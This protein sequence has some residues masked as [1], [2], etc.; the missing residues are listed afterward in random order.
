[1]H[2]KQNPGLADDSSHAGT[3][4]TFVERMPTCSRSTSRRRS[5]SDVASPRRL[6]RTTG[7][8]SARHLATAPECRA[9]ARNAR[10][11]RR[12]RARPPVLRLDRDPEAVRAAA[13]S[14]PSAPPFASQP[15]ASRMR[16]KSTPSGPPTRSGRARIAAA[17]RRRRRATRAASTRAP[18]AR[19]CSAN[20]TTPQPSIAGLERVGEPP[21]L[22]RARRGT[23]AGPDARAGGSPRS[24]SPARDRARASRRACPS[25]CGG[26]SRRPALLEAELEVVLRRAR[27]ARAA[28]RAAATCSGVSW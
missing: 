21:R 23:P 9:G 18:S 3:S 8:S 28:A 1:M 27:P 12:M 20:V 6:L 19:A 15:G 24:A 11:R 14:R 16:R 7:T 10:E 26:S 13:Q 25:S 17:I 5:R 4:R 2:L 22:P